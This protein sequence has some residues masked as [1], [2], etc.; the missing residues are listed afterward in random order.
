MNFSGFFCWVYIVSRGNLKL[1]K[2]E[3][4][5]TPKITWKRFKQNRWTQIFCPSECLNPWIYTQIYLCNNITLCCITHFSSHIR[6]R[7]PPPHCYY[8]VQRSK[9]KLGYF[10]CMTG[11]IHPV[12]LRDNFHSGIVYPASLI[13]DSHMGIE[14]PSSLIKDSHMGIVHPRPHIE[15]SRVGIVQLR[16][17]IYH[18]HEEMQVNGCSLYN[19]LRKKRVNGCP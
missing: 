1:Q 16:P 5:V 14:H 12:S 9:T 17:Q 6:K 3:K 4:L 10:N 2:L 11:I 19:F 18:S 8:M 15:D 13:D 7:L